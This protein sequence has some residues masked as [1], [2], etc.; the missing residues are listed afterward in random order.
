M[1][2]AATTFIIHFKVPQVASQLGLVIFVDV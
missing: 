1:K 2:V